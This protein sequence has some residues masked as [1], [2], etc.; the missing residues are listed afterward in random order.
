L[1]S[2]ENFDNLKTPRFEPLSLSIGRF[3]A[4]SI[5]QRILRQHEKYRQRLW[6]QAF[7]P[8][9]FSSIGQKRTHAARAKPLLSAF[10]LHRFTR[11]V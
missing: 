11:A 10:A 5:T 2:K 6:R 8:A 1:I 4:P 7:A 9:M 3:F